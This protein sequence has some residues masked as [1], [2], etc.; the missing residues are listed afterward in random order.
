MRDFDVCW[1][2]AYKAKPTEWEGPRAAEDARS[3]AEL[4]LEQNY[5]LLEWPIGGYVVVRESGQRKQEVYWVEV[6]LDPIFIAN[7]DE[8]DSG[9]GV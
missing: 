9:H 4:Y 5:E 7:L 8:R 2:G 1:L 3:A 6:R